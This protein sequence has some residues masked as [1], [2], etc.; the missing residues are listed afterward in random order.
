[1]PVRTAYR[2]PHRSLITCSILSSSSP[3]LVVCRCRKRRPRSPLPSRCPA[4]SSSAMSPL[5]QPPRH[6]SRHHQPPCRRSPRLWPRPRP[7]LH[8]RPPPPPQSLPPQPHSVLRSRPPAWHRSP[9]RPRAC[10]ARTTMPLL[11]L[12]RLAHTARSSTARPSTV[13]PNTARPS[14]TTNLITTKDH[15][16]CPCLTSPSQAQARSAPLPPPPPPL[17]P[18]LRHTNTLRHPG[19]ILADQQALYPTTTIQPHIPTPTTPHPASIPAER[20]PVSRMV[21]RQ[22]LLTANQTTA[23]HRA[24][25]LTW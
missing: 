4:P 15:Q 10:L 23:T 16:G 9:H 1:M 22:A 25:A 8:L 11:L 20:T 2:P 5:H 12:S 13:K 6:R 21:F 19:R 18:C 24:I 3:M 17:R 14:S 7:L